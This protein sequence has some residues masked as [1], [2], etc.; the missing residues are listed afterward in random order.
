MVWKSAGRDI[1]QASLKTVLQVSK[2]MHF[3]LGWLEPYAPLPSTSAMQAHIFN[4]MWAPTVTCNPPSLPKAPGM[5]L[6]QTGAFWGL[7]KAVEP[8]F[9]LSKVGLQFPVMIPATEAFP[10]FVLRA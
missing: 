4:G 10:E 3:L 1:L 9:P 7:G 6:R 2:E 5:M 8:K